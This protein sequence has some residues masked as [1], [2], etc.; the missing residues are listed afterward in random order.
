MLCCAPLPPQED[1][2]WIQFDDDK[3]IPRKEEEVAGLSGATTRLALLCGCLAQQG[4]GPGGARCPE[5][6]GSVPMSV[7]S[8]A[9]ADTTAAPAF[10]ASGG[11]DWHMA[12]ML[13]YRAQRVPKLEEAA[14]EGGS[15]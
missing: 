15:A 3:M 1:G 7:L 8:T 13:L 10:G 12:Y 6:L 2:Q 5:E 14:A 11:G 4:E 9:V